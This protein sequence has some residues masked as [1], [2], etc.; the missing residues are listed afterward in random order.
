MNATARQTI[1]TNLATNLKAYTAPGETETMQELLGI[2]EILASEPRVPAPNQLAVTFG[3]LS[4]DD[5]EAYVT[6]LILYFRNRIEDGAEELELKK[7][8][9][10]IC[11]AIFDDQTASNVAYE[12]NEYSE[13]LGVIETAR[14]QILNGAQITVVYRVP[15]AFFRHEKG[16]LI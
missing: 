2:T 16:G 12:I 9:D 13:E 14:E 15:A 4:M 11:P 8:L 7:A 5:D 6:L 1:C 10:M 3:G